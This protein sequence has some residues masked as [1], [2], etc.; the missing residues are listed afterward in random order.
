MDYRYKSDKRKN[1]PPAKIAGEGKIPSVKKKIY[2]YSPRRA[3][4]LRFDSRG[5]PDKLPKLLE[6]AKKR[7]LT[8]E[9][10]R[11]IAEALRTHE[12]WLEWAGK[13]EKKS[14]KVDSVELHIHERVST[15]AILK[16]AKRL[17]V[18]R[19]L[20]ADPELENQKEVQSYQH[21]VDWANRMILGDSLQVM[22]SLAHRENLAGKVQMIYLDPPYGIRFASNFQPELGKR[23]VGDREQDL[24]REPEM[25]KAYQDTWHL[26]KHSYLSYMRDRLRICHD[27]LA[28]SGSVFVQIG[29]ENLHIVR[30]LMD[31]IFKPENFSALICFSKT[32]GLESKLLYGIFD[33]ILWYAKDKK[34]IKYNQLFKSKSIGSAG[35]SKYVS[36]KLVNGFCRPITALEKSNTDSL[37]ESASAFRLDNLTSQGNPVVK[38]EFQGLNYQGSWKTNSDGM[39]RLSLSDR[40]TASKTTLNYVRYIKDFMAFPI[41][42]YWPTGGIQSRSDPKMY[43]VQTATRAIERCLL[44]TTDPGDLVLDPT[45]GSGTTA[46]VAEQ[47]GRRWITMDTSRVAIAI[48][49]QRL[50]TAKYDYYRLRDESKGISE[51]FVCKSVPHITL[52]GIAR[53]E[54]LDPIFG[55]HDPV[56]EEKLGACNLALKKVTR[57]LRSTLSSKLMAKQKAEGKRAITDADRRRWE[58]PK[59]GGKWEHWEIPFDT[60]PDWPRELQ[61]AVTD[62]RNAWIAKMDEV[63]ACIGAYAEHEELVDQPE[64]ERKIIR[65]SGPFGVE[66][67]H[68]PEIYLDETSPQEQSGL[69]DG[70]PDGPEETFDSDIRQT[71]QQNAHAYIDRMIRL[72]RMDGVR[73]PDNRQMR[74]T[75]LEL[76]RGDSAGIHAEGRWAPEGEED[77]A[78]HA[79]ATVCVAFG[80]QYG[81]LTARMIEEVIR[82]ANRMGYDDLIIA[83]FSFD[84]PAQAVIEESR[85]PR[86]KIHAAHIRPDISP[87]MDG[88]LKEQPGSQLFSVFGQPRTKLGGPDKNG[89]YEIVMEGVD[90]YNPVT[91]AIHSTGAEKVAAWF[92]DSNYDGRTFCLTQAFFPDK[93]AWSKLAKALKSHIDPR[94]FEIMSGTTSMPFAPGKHKT[95]AVKVI[96]PRGNEVMKIHKL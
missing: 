73:F 65:V 88:L 6:Q 48:A 17:D 83:G 51:G 64:V 59:K 27:L 82:P 2:A 43:V 90:I 3:P 78:P 44:M 29:D 55:K 26:G 10:V 94:A 18:Q 42:T 31:E 56:L 54:N 84:G 69:F 4:E 85:P 79:R 96:D 11:I 5:K 86:L 22:S 60:D 66:S 63:N 68:P 24:T 38:F 89:E 37:P 49:R 36:L 9:E 30:N 7:P 13:Q 16:A 41:T 71:D 74:F 15:K 57:K 39:R 67:V 70:A 52:K 95:A 19:S 23:D 92:L 76:V 47:W 77:P 87:G 58:L 20:F 93:K 32:G 34:K 35:A 25:V 75:R 33:F 61:K 8:D 14:F 80:P 46:Y 72:L 21:D 28:D 53:N 12:P 62:Y 40:I 45:C 1:I 91:N 50:L 81:P